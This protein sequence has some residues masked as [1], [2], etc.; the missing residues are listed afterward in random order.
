MMFNSES[1]EIKR[2]TDLVAKFEGEQKELQLKYQQLCQDYLLST[3]QIREYKLNYQ[4]LQDIV[5]D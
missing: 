5:S 4:S 3:N 2:L 1:E